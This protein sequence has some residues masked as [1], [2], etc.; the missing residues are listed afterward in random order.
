M[1]DTY[2][3]AAKQGFEKLVSQYKTAKIFEPLNIWFGGNTLHTCLDYLIWTPN[4]DEKKDKSRIVEYAFNAVFKKMNAFPP[5]ARFDCAY[6]S[7]SG[8]WRDDFGW[9]G[10]A[11]LM[12]VNNRVSLGYGDKQNDAMFQEILAAAQCCWVQLLGNW[13]DLPY[14]D[15]DVDQ[16]AGSSDIK[17]GAFNILTGDLMGGRN[18]VTNELFWILSQRLA[19][20]FPNDPLYSA[21][22]AKY[23]NWFGRWFDT[24][25]I[26]TS[27]NLILERPTGNGLASKW[28]WSGDQGL[29]IEALPADDPRRDKI[30]QAAQETLAE[31]GVLHE[32]VKDLT[33]S[34]A[35]FMADYATGKGIF[36]RNLAR[37]ANVN[38]NG[39]YIKFITDNASTVWSH[40]D[41]TNQFPFNWDLSEP[42][43]EENIL[44]M[45][46]EDDR[47]NKPDDLCD[48]IMQSAG[49]D[50]LN[51]AMLIAPDEPIA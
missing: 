31:K 29:M 25:Q 35:G 14:N 22:A 32:N 43:H 9:W 13:R 19:Q 23:A 26:L 34:L 3:S 50:A 47:Q 45:K 48:L 6:L 12:A 46:T 38:K 8:W 33:G 7:R 10:I 36:M 49:Q 30:A 2:Q 20:H 44:R 17:G 41:K 51:A 5:G 24:G 15:D 21:Q 27:Q 37:F 18:S 4:S 1:P 16:A 40:R 42:K 11:L 39:D 28:Y